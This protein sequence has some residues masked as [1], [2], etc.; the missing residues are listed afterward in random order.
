MFKPYEPSLLLSLALLM[1]PMPPPN[2]PEPYE[3]IP[4][5]IP[6]P[7]PPDPYLGILKT[8]VFKLLAG[9]EAAAAPCPYGFLLLNPAPATLDPV[10]P[11]GG[12]LLF[13]LDTPGPLETP[14]LLPAPLEETPVP[15]DGF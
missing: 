4:P 15:D 5:P 12:I 11:I 9:L 13:R 2:P 6:P 1:P 10:F 3:P 7:S 14:F 8:F